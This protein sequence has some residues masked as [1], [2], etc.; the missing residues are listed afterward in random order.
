MAFICCDILRAHSFSVIF[1]FLLV[2]T[3]TLLYSVLKYMLNYCKYKEYYLIDHEFKLT[4]SNS[5]GQPPKISH[6]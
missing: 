4:S 6:E 2:I 3:N 5:G 1:I